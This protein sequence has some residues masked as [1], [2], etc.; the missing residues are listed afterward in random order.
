MSAWW[1]KQVLVLNILSLLQQFAEQLSE[2][3]G[4]EQV[5]CKCLGTQ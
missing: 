4:E 1:Y 2:L 3:V 5:V